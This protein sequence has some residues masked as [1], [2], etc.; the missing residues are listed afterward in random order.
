MSLHHSVVGTGPER[1]VFL[2][3]LFGQGKNFTSIASAIGDVATSW[4]VDQPNHGRSPWTLGFSL[5][6]QADVVAAWMR[7][8][9]GGPATL[10]GHSLGGKVAMRITLRHPELVGRLMVVDT[11]P[12]HNQATS[13]FSVLVSAMRNLDVSAVTS[14]TDADARMSS[15]I[16]DASV[17]GFLLQ[18]LRKTSGNWEWNANLDLLGDNLHVV[19][20]WPAMDESWDGPTWWVVG[21]R[22][23]YVQP[24]DM[25]AMRALFPR[26]V[27]VTLKRAGHW[28]HADEPQAFTDI[29]LKFLS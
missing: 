9:V 2:H 29:L 15:L 3:G 16:P 14:R 4:L 25:P 28:V 18:N 12:T 8:T 13:H 24:S 26:V 23:D 17:R 7:D 19:A 27:S 6:E 10:V 21:G 11:S 1:V 5:D 20:G 22:S